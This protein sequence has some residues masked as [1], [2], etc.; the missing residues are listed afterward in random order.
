[1]LK[2]NTADDSKTGASDQKNPQIPSGTEAKDPRL[3]YP[4][5]LTAAELAEIMRVDRRV[6]YD[7]VDANEIPGVRGFGRQLRIDRDVVLKW[8]ADGQGRAPRSPSRRR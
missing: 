2:D 5:V 6:I 8:L 3:I 4:P 7:M 1:M